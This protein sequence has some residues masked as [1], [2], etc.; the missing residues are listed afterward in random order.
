MWYALSCILSCL[1][2]LL[3][4]LLSTSV[5]LHLVESDFAGSVVIYYRH[6][7]AGIVVCCR[8]KVRG[9][10]LQFPCDRF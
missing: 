8:M 3:L 2:L 6:L 1:L 4:T 9:D 7:T 10:Q 5:L